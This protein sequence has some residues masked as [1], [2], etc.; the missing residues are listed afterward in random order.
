M[1]TI[2]RFLSFALFFLY[3]WAPPSFSKNQTAPSPVGAW[4][5]SMDNDLFS[6]TKNSDSDFTGGFS[7]SYGGSA[8][9]LFHRTLDKGQ[10]RIDAFALG[11]GDFREHTKGI[12]FGLYGFTPNEIDIFGVLPEDRPYASLL[13]ASSNRSYYSNTNKNSWASSLTI[14]V[15]GLGL[16]GSAQNGIHKALG[17]ESA[18]GWRNQVSDGGELTLRYQLA[19]MDQW[20]KKSDSSFPTLRTTYFASLGYLTEFGIS[21]S[22]MSSVNSSFGSRFNPELISYGEK[23]NDTALTNTDQKHSFWGGVSLKARLYNAFLQG[24]FKQSVHSLQK[25]QIETLLLEA[26]AG[27]TYRISREYT[28]SYV[29]RWQSPELKAEPGRRELVWGALIFSRNL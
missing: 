3:L 12:E 27:Y 5:I 16:F 4:A 19:Y 1:F 24:Q 26:W 23:V 17:S 29:L 21:L 7:F 10:G 20:S 11:E 14:G 18:N 6:P 2:P 15:L 13:Y 22:S 28:L 9:Q 8:N 25:H